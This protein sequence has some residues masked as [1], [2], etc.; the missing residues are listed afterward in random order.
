MQSLT[1]VINSLQNRLGTGQQKQQKQLSTVFGHVIK[2]ILP[3]TAEKERNSAMIAEQCPSG[4]IKSLQ[5]WE[6]RKEGKEKKQAV[7]HTVRE[8]KEREGKRR[9]KEFSHL[10]PFEWAGK[11]SLRE[12]LAPGGDQQ[13]QRRQQ[14]QQQISCALTNHLRERKLKLKLAT[15]S[16]RE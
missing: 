7:K 10:G 12:R 15:L 5:L 3:S 16:L 6:G 11:S 13:K 1:I 9:D 8:S 4:T 14:Q 2:K